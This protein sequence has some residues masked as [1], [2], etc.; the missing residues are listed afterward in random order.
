MD[1]QRFD[2][3]TR[4]LASSTSR[5]RVLQ[6][7]LASPLAALASSKL[8]GNAAAQEDCG[9]SLRSCMQQAADEFRTRVHACR[10][11]SR[12]ELG[13]CIELARNALDVRSYQCEQSFEA[14]QAGCVAATCPGEDTECQTRICLETGC[15]FAY[16]PVGTPVTA[17]TA[18]DCLQNV[19]DGSGGIDAVPDDDDCCLP[20]GSACETG[21]SCCTSG[22][23]VSGRCCLTSSN[24]CTVD[25]DCCPPLGC[26]QTGGLRICAN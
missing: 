19:C 20:L 21:I 2:A 16:Q 12:S 24:F 5:R 10:S 4:N 23:C 9:D 25:A 22:L 13:A 3:L 11:G 18:G 7:L 1:P 26:V 17:Q 14:C 6:F 8:L 15:G